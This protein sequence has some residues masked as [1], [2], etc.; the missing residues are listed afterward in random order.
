MVQLTADA[1]V[2]RML[3]RVLA[4]VLGLVMIALGLGMMVTVVMLPAGVIILLLGIL[5]LLYGAFAPEPRA[6]RPPN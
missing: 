4:V 3:G 2:G 1:G 6:A 5:M